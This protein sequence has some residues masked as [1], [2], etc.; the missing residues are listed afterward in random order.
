MI[1]K[2]L[3]SIEDNYN[4]TLINIVSQSNIIMLCKCICT[5]KKTKFS[6]MFV[7]NKCNDTCDNLMQGISNQFSGIVYYSL[8]QVMH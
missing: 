4:Q 1:S 5:H 6:K 7:E 8:M 2:L 3:P